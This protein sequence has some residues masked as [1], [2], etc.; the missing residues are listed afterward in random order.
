MLC[1]ALTVN[2]FSGLGKK[3]G[4]RGVKRKRKIEREKVSDTDGGG[5]GEMGGQE[6]R[7]DDDDKTQDKLGKEKS[8]KRGCRKRGSAKHDS[9]HSDRLTVIAPAGR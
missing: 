9:C 6:E 1:T 5:G 3:G 2:P 4:E 7:N 8:I